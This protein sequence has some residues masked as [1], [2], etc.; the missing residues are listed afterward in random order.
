[1]SKWSLSFFCCG[2]GQFQLMSSVAV[3]C[4]R[5]L[6]HM[7]EVVFPLFHE[8]ISN[9]SELSLYALLFLMALSPTI[10]EA[11]FPQLLG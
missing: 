8:T 11:R 10:L 9:L 6:T 3:G 1:M 7:Q 5:I 2:D 4:V